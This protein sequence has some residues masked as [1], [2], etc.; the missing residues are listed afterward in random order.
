MTSSAL[1]IAAASRG[2]T[3][4]AASLAVGEEDQRRPELD[5]VRAAERLAAAVFDLDVADAG[6]GLERAARSAAGRRGSGRTTCCRTRAASG[7]RGRRWRRGSA[8]RRKYRSE[9]PWHRARQT[10]RRIDC[11]Q[12]RT[13]IAARRAGTNRL[14][15][16]RRGAGTSRRLRA[17]RARR[18]LRVLGRHALAR[19]RRQRRGGRAPRGG[20]P[21][22]ARRL[23]RP[24]RQPSPAPCATCRGHTVIDRGVDIESGADLIAECPDC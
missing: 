1:S 5:A 18:P 23:A 13:T 11:R 12:M 16:C 17:A 15:R 22:P 10:T 6:T 7:R 14:V 24:R 19:R 9:G 20:E 21:D 2:R 4:R 8:R 3:R